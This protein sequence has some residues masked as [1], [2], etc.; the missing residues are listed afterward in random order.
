MGKDKGYIKLYRSILDNP[1]WKH[2][3]F[4]KG[5]A[6]I[7]LLLLANHKDIKI[8][9][10][11]DFVTYK[12][13]T[14]TTSI[15]KLE[16]RWHW[17]KNK[18][19]SYLKALER[20]GMIT[21]KGTAKGTTLTIVNYSFYQNEGTTKGTAEG[22]TEG[23]TKGTTKGTLTRMNKNVKELYKNVEEES[24]TDLLEQIERNVLKGGIT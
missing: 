3:P 12:R 4:S 9:Q 5:Q 22:T 11:A 21:Q 1:L 18:I 7:D 20:D 19:R 24:D 6:W 17:S 16:Y 13:G 23:T 15:P 14:V 2:E 10:G 8:L